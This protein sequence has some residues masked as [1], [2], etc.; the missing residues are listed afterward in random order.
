MQNTYIEIGRFYN[1]GE[2]EKAV[3]ALMKYN[4]WVTGFTL[5]SGEF[6]DVIESFEENYNNNKSKI[7]EMRELQQKNQ[8]RGFILTIWIH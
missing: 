4:E 3:N 2:H 8:S 7:A 6:V 1:A 5:S